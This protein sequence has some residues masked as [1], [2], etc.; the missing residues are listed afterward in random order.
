MLFNTIEYW[1]FFAAVLGVYYAAR[2]VAGRSVL[3]AASFVFYAAW[4]PVLA[5]LLAASALANWGFGLAVGERDHRARKA[6][7]VAAVAANLSLLVFFKYLNMLAATLA[8]L[9]GLPADRWVFDILLPVGVSFFTFEGIAYVV[10]VYRRDVRPRANPL[11]IA[12][13]FSFFPHLVAGPIIRPA[14]F[15]PQIEAKRVP[16]PSDVEWGVL[17][18]VKGLIKKCV[19]ADNLAMVADAYFSGGIGQ[20]GSA[21]ALAGVLAFSFQIYFDFSGYTDIARGCAR[22]LGYDF[23]PNFARP[24]L[25]ADIAEFWRRWHI[26]LSTWL[27][28]YL[29]IPLG[30]NRRGEAR[31]H[32]NLL[33][34]M[35][36]GGLWH[37]AS[38]NFA[39]WG[40]YHGLLLVAHRLWRKL[41]AG[42]PAEL[43]FAGRIGHAL[44]VAL[45]F[46]LVTLGWITFRTPDFATSLAVLRDIFAFQAGPAAPVPPALAVLT[47]AA[48]AWCLLDRSARVQAWLVAGGRLRVPLALAAS[49]LVLEL[50]AHNETAVPFIYFQF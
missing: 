22:L 41:A 24:Y 43:L 33:A 44:G 2:G 32:L 50:F 30:G 13:L 21:A 46:S 14:E 28:D 26:S 34:T 12:L 6:V 35:G 15:F 31:T 27:R 11:D 36:L 8:A 10:D 47:L 38:W 5:L 48:A 3:V 1:V 37:G 9:L 49:L 4:H 17:Q 42:T 7:L 25:S 29:Y 23:P 19:F 20:A 45:T 39:I 18:V 16:S 40:L